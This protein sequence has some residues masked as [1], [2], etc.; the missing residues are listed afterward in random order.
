MALPPRS[1]LAL[2]C[3]F[4]YV[5]NGS[6]NNKIHRQKVMCALSTAVLRLGPCSNT[7]SCL[8]S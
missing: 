4:C 8:D 6:H 1:L 7:S 3:F 5:G 2:A